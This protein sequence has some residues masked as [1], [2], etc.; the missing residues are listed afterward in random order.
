MR[1]NPSLLATSLCILMLLARAH[2]ASWD[3]KGADYLSAKRDDFIKSFPGLHRAKLPGGHLLYSEQSTRLILR[4]RGQLPVTH[5][6]FE[7]DAD[8]ADGRTLLLAEFSTGPDAS[9]RYVATF[10]EGPSTDPEFCFHSATDLHAAGCIP[11]E[12]LAILPSGILSVFQRTNSHFP[13]RSTWRLLAGAVVEA[14][15]AAYS[16]DLATVA[17]NP[18]EVF[19]KPAGGEIIGHLQKGTSIRVLTTD[20]EE[21]QGWLVYLIRAKSGLRGYVRVGVAQCPTATLRNLCWFG[22]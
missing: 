20:G 4:T 14:K 9:D 2:S 1:P 16:V 22:D 13:K 11:G 21:R 18:L 17:L 7:Q 8:S 3:W 19:D 12:V 5:P 15:P 6:L 10:D